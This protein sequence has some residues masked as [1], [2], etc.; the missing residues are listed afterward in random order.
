MTN[1]LI[2][3]AG[4]IKSINEA[5]IEQADKD[6]LL[7]EL[8]EMDEETRISLFKTLSEICLLGMEEKQAK[9]RIRKNWVK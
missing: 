5:K 9:E 1:S 6:F 2:N 7:S 3:N 8:P 4:L